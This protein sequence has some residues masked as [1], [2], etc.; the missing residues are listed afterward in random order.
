[1]GKPDEKPLAL[2]ITCLARFDHLPRIL[3]L[4]A[5]A[6]EIVGLGEKISYAVQVAVDE[7]CTNIIEHAYHGESDDPIECT[8]IPE[9]HQLTIILRDRGQPFDPE[10]IPIPNVSACLEERQSGGLGLYFIR[11]LMDEVHFEF[12][13]DTDGQ[14][15]L[16]TLTMIKRKETSR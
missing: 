12:G 14:H 13:K 15:P 11:K 8:C 1:M 16:N 9:P 3:G 5:Q 6:V 4:V 2:T 10:A 7:A